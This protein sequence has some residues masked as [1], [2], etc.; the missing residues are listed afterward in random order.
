MNYRHLYHAGNFADVMKH[1]LL[2]ELV[3]ALQRKEK[4]FLYVDTHAGRGRYDLEAAAKGDTLIRRPEWPEG[5]GRLWQENAGPPSVGRYLRLVREFDRQ[6][7]NLTGSPRF[8]PGSP[9]LVRRLARPVDRLVVCERHPAEQAALRELFAREEGTEVREADGYAAL[10][11]VLPP[12]ERRALVLLDPPYE[13]ADEF[14]LLLA[15]LRE[16]LRRFPRGVFAVWYPLT[17]RARADEFLA[18]VRGE[19]PP[20]CLAAELSIAGP[21]AGLKMR[22]CGLLVVNPPW[23]FDAAAG[24]ILAHLGRVLAQAPGGEASVAWLVRPT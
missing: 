19:T 15:A 16:G 2:V 13:A 17:E 7:G 21:A 14:F 24:E 10:R 12:P 22:G 18:A 11:A 23:Q 6:A 9:S 5:I 3:A 20:P 4:G 8:Y 1:V